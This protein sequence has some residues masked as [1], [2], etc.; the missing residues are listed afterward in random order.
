MKTLLQSLR[1][2]L[3]LTVLTGVVYPLAVWAVGRLSFHDA[4][5]GSLLTRDGRVVGSAL[6]AQ[7]FTSNR[8]FTS[9]PSAGDFATVA[10]GASNLAWTSAKLRDRLAAA[11]A[12]Q[13]ADLAT[14]SGSGLD[15]HLSP[16]AVAVQL[17]RVATAR[18]LDAARRAQLNE[19]VARHTEGGQLTPQ[20]VNIL[21]LNL[22]LD[23]AFPSTP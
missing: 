11:P 6:L 8:Y 23:A 7:K 17:D 22:A 9:R 21:Q 4:A 20:R 15:P 18:H 19:L 2:F 10:S 3:V 14:T 1:L 12:G 5:E 13:P 16:E